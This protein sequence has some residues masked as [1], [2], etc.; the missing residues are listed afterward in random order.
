M[1]KTIKKKSRRS[2]N[3]NSRILTFRGQGAVETVTARRDEMAFF[4]RARTTRNGNGAQDV[5][6]Y[7][8][9]CMVPTRLSGHEA[10]TL[11]TLLKR[12]FEETDRSL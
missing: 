9:D 8:R 11:Y 12:H 5:I 7:P 4:A 1:R 10:R 6:L 3:K 2:V